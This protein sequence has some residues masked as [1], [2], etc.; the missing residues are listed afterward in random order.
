M[1]LFYIKNIEVLKIEFVET[2]GDY[3]YEQIKSKLNRRAALFVPS[4]D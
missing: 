4:R 2:K 1:L 3:K